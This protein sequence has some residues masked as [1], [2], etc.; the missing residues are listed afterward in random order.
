MTRAQTTLGDDP[1]LVP[2]RGRGRTQDRQDFT[3][4]IPSTDTHNLVQFVFLGDIIEAALEI[5]IFNHGVEK[6]EFD[7]NSKPTPFFTELDD[8]GTL[9]PQAEKAIRLYGKYIF[10]D[11]AIPEPLQAPLLETHWHKYVN[12]ADLPIELESFR[13]FWFNNVISKPQVKR[14]FLKNLINDL[15]NSLIPKAIR[16]KDNESA[17]SNSTDN[18]QAMLNYFSLLGDASYLNIAALS[19]YVDTAAAQRQEDL[20]AAAALLGV[21]NSHLTTSE[22]TTTSN[23]SAPYAPYIPFSQIRN[24]ISLAHDTPSGPNTFNVF[25]IHQKPSSKIDRLGIETAD[26]EA[27]IYH[28]KISENPKGMLRSIQFKRMD[29]P[30]LQV[31]NLLSDQG[32]NKLGILREKYDANVLLK[33]NVIY[34]PGSVLFVSHNHIQ[35]APNA[36]DHVRSMNWGISTTAARSLGLGGYFVVITVSHDWGNIAD[37]GEWVTTLEA[38]WLSFENSTATAGSCVYDSPNVPTPCLDQAQDQYDIGLAAQSRGIRS[39]WRRN[40]TGLTG[41]DPGAAAA[42]EAYVTAVASDMYPE[43]YLDYD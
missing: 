27:G 2:G 14:Y 6:G 19:E 31:A 3:D 20:A 9:G 8:D 17:T 33:G 36:P 25:V 34:K 21:P 29:L 15:I 16:N 28:F 37:G 39:N 22:P 26:K 7:S 11:I 18:P 10:G 38:K 32:S 30:S 35:Q 13:T 24:Q 43:N 23:A 40:Q 12:L 4:T 5:I 41:V 42:W 1:G